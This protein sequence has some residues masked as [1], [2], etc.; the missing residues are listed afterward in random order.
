[1]PA[2]FVSHTNTNNNLSYHDSLI[3]KV[4]DG[5]DGLKVVEG[6][7]G[8]DVH[9][10]NQNFPR[11][12]EVLTR[13][14]PFSP[15]LE[16]PFSLEDVGYLELTKADGAMY[17]H[18]LEYL[19][20]HVICPKSL[21]LGWEQER[22]ADDDADGERPAFVVAVSSFAPGHGKTP[23]VELGLGWHRLI[24]E[25]E[26]GVKRTIHVLSQTLGQPIG[27]FRDASFFHSLI[28]FVE[29]DDRQ[30]A[31]QFIEEFLRTVWRVSTK[32]DKL[33]VAIWRFDLKNSFWSRV[34]AR[35]PRDLSL[36]VLEKDV[37]KMIVDDLTWFL[38]EDTNDF[39]S[40]HGIPYHRAYLFH[41][42]PG[43][44]KTSTIFA[45]AGAF[46]RNLCFIQSD[47]HMTDDNFRIAVGQAPPK[48]MIVLEDVDSMFTIHRETNC[49]QSSLS[50]SGFLN[51]IDG[52]ASPEDI[53]FVL[54]TNHPERLDPALLRPGRVDV[55]VEF[56]TPN[57][58][59]VKEYFLTYYPDKEAAVIFAKKI[60]DERAA[61][62]MAQMQ[63]YFLYCHRHK[64]GAKEAAAGVEHFCWQKHL[65]REEVSLMY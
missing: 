13:T 42:P 34:V 47:T 39:Y 31:R 12:A 40:R 6:P 19:P 37:K 2:D 18:I 7:D 9:P 11:K 57:N 21:R 52:L 60:G 45:I 20:K 36:V 30:T 41:G 62:S 3:H 46:E 44:G 15:E 54:T 48:S 4:H 26:D 17:E 28:F 38:K 51:T 23:S 58:E 10:L 61:V 25:F 59:M 53:V 24:H 29:G 35:K 43:S 33:Q 64:R 16:L 8:Y 63:H 1:M 5:R 22:S 32:V 56:K 27:T 65:G 49:K 14:L 50:F 55:R